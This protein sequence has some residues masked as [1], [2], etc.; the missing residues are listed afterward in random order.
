[1]ADY[2]FTITQDYFS[3]EQHTDQNALAAALVTAPSELTPVITHLVGRTENAY[4]ISFL[5]EGQGK[6]ESFDNYD[7]QWRVKTRTNHARPIAV[8]NATPNLGKGGTYFT[9]TFP[10]RWFV[11]GYILVSQNGVQVI[12]QGAPT[13]N[14]R[15]WDYR[16][17]LV[18][19]SANPELSLP[20]EDAQ[21]GALWAQMYAVVAFDWS[22]GNASNWSAP[23]KVRGR[24]SKLRK[25]YKFSGS[26]KNQVA[27]F[28]LPMEGGRRTKMWMDYEEYQHMLD[29]YEERE[30][31]YWYGQASF[32]GRG[33]TH[34]E[35]ENGQRINSS[36]GLFEQIINRDTYST[37]TARKLKNVIGDMFYGMTDTQN[38]QVVLYTGQGGLEEF[39]NAMK[40]ELAS[41]TYIKLDAG[42]FVTGQGRT[43]EL[44]GYFTTY[45]HVN[46]HTIQVKHL[47]M[48]DHGRFAQVRKKHPVTGWS[49]ESYRMVFVD[50]SIYDGEPNIKM[51]ARKGE[52]MKRWAVAGSTVPNG[53]GS[54]SQLLRASGV[55]G[56][57][58]HWQCTKGIVMRRFNTSVDFQCVAE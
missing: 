54:D 53:Y 17:Q 58:V 15:N 24:M 20:A 22:N 32:N 30:H 51:V 50:Q 25:S 13:P 49:L 23:G 9:L 7:F 11:P 26:V 55:D 5:T 31:F 40:E 3:D 39:D 52:E 28:D 46:G 38:K 41:R 57:E 44:G 33:V 45:Q 6:V 8:T 47:P 1:M 56:A 34:L 36:P 29:W 27:V 21:A 19:S 35:D 42:K 16:V 14:G 48:F 4:P 18:K 43:L 2:P 37:L 10:D 12:I